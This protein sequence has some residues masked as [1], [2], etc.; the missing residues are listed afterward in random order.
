MD[1]VNRNIWT[2]AVQYPVDG[3]ETYPYSTHYYSS[4]KMRLKVPIQQRIYR[5]H[6]FALN[7]RFSNDLRPFACWWSRYD[8]PIIGNSPKSIQPNENFLNPFESFNLTIQERRPHN[9]VIPNVI[10]IIE[11]KKHLRGKPLIFLAT[12][13]SGWNPKAV[14]FKMRS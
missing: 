5:K 14:C 10:L 8:I 7:V 6:I 4:N 13:P 3:T 12:N 11:F 9:T 2:C 1:Q